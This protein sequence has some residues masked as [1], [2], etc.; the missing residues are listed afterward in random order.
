MER[1]HL[2][3]DFILMNMYTNDGRD[4][5]HK[6][7]FKKINQ[8]RD[9][10]ILLLTFWS[11]GVKESRRIYNISATNYLV[12]IWETGFEGLIVGPRNKPSYVLA[13]GLTDVQIALIRLETSC[14]IR[15]DVIRQQ[16]SKQLNLYQMLHWP[17]WL[18]C[19]DM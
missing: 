10:E 17:I 3:L 16:S 7:C 5:T 2:D 19:T 15:N 14:I 9:C 4:H 8:L 18:Q 1:A 12:G 6:Y 13:V 11:A